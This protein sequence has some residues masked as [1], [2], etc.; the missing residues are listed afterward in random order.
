[1]S[2]GTNNGG[3]AFPW[4]EHNGDG[5]HCWDHQGI[6]MRDYLAAKAMQSM[7]PMYR[8]DHYAYIAEQAYH[9]ADAMLAARELP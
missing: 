1:M 9:M 2:N 5:S 7:V 3:G 6:S 4:Q 8:D